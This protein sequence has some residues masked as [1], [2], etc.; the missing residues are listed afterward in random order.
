MFGCSGEMIEEVFSM[1]VFVHGTFPGVWWPSLEVTYYYPV[2]RPATTSMAALTGLSL[3][4][5]HI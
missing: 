1:D 3:V 2:F 4:E 5:S